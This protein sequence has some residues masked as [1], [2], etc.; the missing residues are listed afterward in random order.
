EHPEVTVIELQTNTGFAVAANRG[1]AAAG[2][3]LV[4][5][6][7]T[8]VVLEPDWLDRMAAALGADPASASAACKMLDLA[9]RRLVYDA[10]DVLRRDGAC[11]QRGRFELDAPRF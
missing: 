6:V 7:N 11:E 8:D 9:D 5:L 4:A 2:G 10:G 3:E 1:I